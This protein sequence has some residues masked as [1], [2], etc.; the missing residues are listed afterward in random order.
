METSE[1]IDSLK[2]IAPD[3]DE[4]TIQDTYSE[5]FNDYLRSISVNR[6][7]ENLVEFID[8]LQDRLELRDK[9]I[10]DV[11]CG[12]GLH[13]I[14]FAHFN[15]DVTGIDVHGHRIPVAKKLRGLFDEYRINIEEGDSS[16]SHLD[17][18]TFD[19]AYCNEFVSHV[20][21]LEGTLNEIRRVLKKGGMVIIADT[22]KLS[23]F[24]L[25]TRYITLPRDYEPA[26]LR[27]RKN[28]I[29]DYAASKNLNIEDITA[30]TI[31]RKTR[32][33]T[34]KE[35]RA[36]MEKYGLGEKRLKK[37]ISIHRPKF[38]FVDPAAGVY[39]ER[40]FTPGE[41]FKILKDQGFSRVYRLPLLNTS[42]LALKNSDRLSEK[43]KYYGKKFR[44]FRSNKYVVVGVK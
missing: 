41:I 27:Q 1:I 10:L 12:Y 11:G 30:G 4:K 39:E 17:D 32:G 9:K 19:V 21:D 28:I 38:P 20:Y 18:S 33:W 25:K 43:L 15:N 24:Y 37:L 23:L 42:D 34:K 36:L 29:M 2:R 22:T 44:R 14:I 16:N 3:V 6:T 26:F 8:M 35:L 13:S 31:A 7:A 5:E 40:L